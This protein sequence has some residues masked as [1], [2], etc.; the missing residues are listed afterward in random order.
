[1]IILLCGYKGCGKDT[2]ASYIENTYGFCHMKISKPLKQALKVLFEFSDEQIE[3]NLKDIIDDRW[4]I[5]PR[6]AMIYIGTNVFQHSIQEFLP[7]TSRNFWVKRLV[8]EIKNHNVKS[9]NIVI[10]DLRFIHEYEYIK[11]SFPDDPIYILKIVRPDLKLYDSND[12][13]NS[14]SEHLKLRFS[15]ILTNETKDNFYKMFDDIYNEILTE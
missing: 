15:F 3:G 11:D 5:T 2:M 1:M 6:M 10:S 7:N 9:Q 13:D 4:G 8:D 12:I 14:E